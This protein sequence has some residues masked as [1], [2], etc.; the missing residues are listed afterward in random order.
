MYM[1]MYLLYP[2]HHSHMLN[3]T[4]RLAISIQR[5]PSVVNWS[6]YS[7]QGSRSDLTAA[8]ILPSCSDAAV[9]KERALSYLK[10]F[11]VDEFRDLKELRPFVHPMQSLAPV[12]KATVVPMKLLFKDEKYAAENVAILEQLVKDAKLVGNNEVCQ[13]KLVHVMPA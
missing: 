7:P 12:S 11:L 1:Y 2:D 13:R 5:I 9:V 8:D 6:D 10:N 4:T 3:V